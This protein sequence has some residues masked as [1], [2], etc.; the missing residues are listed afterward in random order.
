MSYDLVGGGVEIVGQEDIR[1]M[2]NDAG[3]N[4]ANSPDMQAVLTALAANTFR[5]V[6]ERGFYKRREVPL[7]FQSAAAIAAG[8]TA[9]VTTQPQ[10]VFR[11]DRLVVPSDIAGSFDINDFVVGKNS[12]FA[13]TATPIPGRIFQEDAVNVSL[14]G[15]TAQISQNVTLNV[16]NFSGAPLTFRAAVIGPA[17]E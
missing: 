12:Q 2:L 3:V 7:G 16:T 4:G 1:Q 8:A 17:V 15:D 10:V 5:A 11:P 6:R 14:L 13:S 9:N